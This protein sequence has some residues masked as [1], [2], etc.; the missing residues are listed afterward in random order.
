MV[1]VVKE[2]KG[3]ALVVRLSGSIEESVNFEQLIG[4]P[5]PEMNIHCK[6]VPRIN[7]VGVKSWIKYFQSAQQKGSKLRFYECSTAIV[8][9][10]N[11]ISNFICGG[12]VE[13]IYVPFSCTNCKSEL[14]G[15][16]RTEDLRKLQLKLPQLKCTKCGGSAVFDDIEEE[17]FAF[18]NR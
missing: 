12:T 16:F 15:Q 9:Q 1:N 13:S 5:A 6:E 18:L 4:A 8:E 11:L 3:S 2:Q 17:Y 7:S 14:I 10:I